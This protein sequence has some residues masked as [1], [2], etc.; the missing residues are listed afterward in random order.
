MVRAVFE[1]LHAALSYEDF[2][3][4]PSLLLRRGSDPAWGTHWGRSQEATS[5]PVKRDWIL[6]KEV[7]NPELQVRAAEAA[8]V[9]KKTNLTD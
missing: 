2:A 9:G 7:W 6:L 3:G 5:S 1:V 4:V 8:V